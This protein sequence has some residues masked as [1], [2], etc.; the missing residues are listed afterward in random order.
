VKRVDGGGTEVPLV[1]GS[2]AAF[3]FNGLTDW[4]RDGRLLLVDRTPVD[5]W[6][7]PFGN[8]KPSPFIDGTTTA[9]RLAQFSPDGR[10]VAYQ[11]N[12]SGRH[13]IFVQAFPGPGGRSQVST[14]GGAQPRWRDDG[15]EL[16]WIAPDAKLMAAPIAVVGDVVKPGAPV[17][18]FETRIFLG[19][20][21]QPERGQY[22][23][24]GDGRF[25]INSVVLSV[26]AQSP[27]INVVE[28]WFEEL[29]RLAP[30]K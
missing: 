9:E 20:A 12:E 15:K 10:W 3:P 28:N 29:K 1:E 18:L 2:V 25:L 26:A 8:G 16:F 27:Q 14:A 11:S 4:S 6:V 7:I 5:L 23:V 19:G 24:S 22:D 30:T 13:E 21:D 17:A